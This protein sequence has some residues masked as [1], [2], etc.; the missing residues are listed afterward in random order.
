MLLIIL[1]LSIV[2]IVRI[3]LLNIPL[4]RDEAEYAYG[5]QLILNGHFPYLE[6]YSLKYPGMFF[7]YSVILFV[8]GQSS[9]AIHIG[10][11]FTNLLSCYLLFAISKKLLN[12]FSAIIITSFFAL[13]SLN[14][15]I[16]GFSANAEHFV[17]LFTLAGL[18]YLFKYYETYFKKYLFLCGLMM[19]ISFTMKQHGF[20]FIILGFL[21]VLHKQII[22]KVTFF[23]AVKNISIYF[24]GVL[25]FI[26][27]T[28]CLI[29]FLGAFEKFWFLTFTY[30]R[31]YV[32]Y[33]N[34]EQGFNNFIKNISNVIKEDY[35]FWI[36][37]AF[38]LFSLIWSKTNRLQMFFVIAFLLTSLLAISPGFYFR[39]HYF[40]LL[41]PI[42]AILSGLFFNSFNNYKLESSKKIFA[43]GFPVLL[44]IS[45]ISFYVYSHS[46]YL[47]KLS[48][49]Q[50]SKMMFGSNPFSESPEIAKYISENSLEND[51][52]AI[53][54]AEPQ[55]L[56]YSKRKSATGYLYV[57]PFLE[58]N[59][60]ADQMTH[61]FFREIE[62]SN[63]KII[64]FSNHSGTWFGDETRK[65][66][67]MDWFN[68]LV[69]NNYY[70]SGIVDIINDTTTNYYWDND[71]NNNSFNG[72]DLLTVYKKIEKN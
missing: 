62:K 4:D 49:I 56:F 7:I 50:V 21:L 64:V 28:L 45:L 58:N 9:M 54:G 51:N 52:V 38:G 16:Q 60:Y 26:I 47:F 6:Q 10:L 35:L 39:P 42:V 67:I 34:L 17:V 57:Y 70:K 29:F 20:A 36:I 40:I 71:V 43:L 72:D 48:P 25:S 12:N 44:F 46:S 65:K 30:A 69:N 15:N 66:E 19:A 32:S 3:R 18:F 59:L 2:I 61:E 5:G 14:E 24:S 63:P 68:N 22:L 55:M 31:E 41:L 13:L 27:F 8:F 33:I 37:S 1:I 23:K 53:I 11:L